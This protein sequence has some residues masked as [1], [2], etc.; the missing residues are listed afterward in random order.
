MNSGPPVSS[1]TRPRG[2]PIPA[3]DH[4]PAYSRTGS[5]S[6][7]ATQKRIS[8]RSI[9]VM[10]PRIPTQ[11]QAKDSDALSASTQPQKTPNAGAPKSSP[12]GA[13]GRAPG[14]DA[15]CDA[16]TTVILCSNTP[17]SVADTV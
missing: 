15:G 4:T 16:A 1:S 10:P 12:N 11:D 3:N 2:Q 5:S 8:V 6:S 17:G 13:Q 7:A 9:A 14:C